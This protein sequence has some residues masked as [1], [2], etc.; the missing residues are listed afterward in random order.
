MTGLVIEAATTGDGPAMLGLLASSGL[1]TDGLMEHPGC[2][3]VARRN[4]YLV[5]LA[6]LELYED[7]A[8][9]RS[10]AV[11]PADRGSGVARLLVERALAEATARDLPAVYLLTTTAER[12]FPRFGFGVV[13][14]ESVPPSVQQS[15]E[16]R[17]ACPASATVM[18]KML[19]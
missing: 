16:F 5:G 11:D 13:P 17:S 8:L 3:Y 7:G 4:H 6:A 10:V 2:A 18:R 19:R 9:L 1:P 14:R 15:I 12:Y